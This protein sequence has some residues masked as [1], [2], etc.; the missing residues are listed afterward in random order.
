MCATEIFRDKNLITGINHSE[1]HI[2]STEMS[3][4]NRWLSISEFGKVT[5]SPTKTMNTRGSVEKSFHVWFLWQPQEI[6]PLI[7]P[8]RR[9]KFGLFCHTF[10]MTHSCKMSVF[11]CVIV[12]HDYQQSWAFRFV[13]LVTKVTFYVTERHGF[14]NFI[15]SF[16]SLHCW[17]WAKKRIFQKHPSETKLFYVELHN[18]ELT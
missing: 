18:T 2:I 13:W 9:R 15:L 4:R 1:N 6:L 14:S 10:Y 16:L 12:V 3:I 5:R 17:Q 7:P 8:V 11:L